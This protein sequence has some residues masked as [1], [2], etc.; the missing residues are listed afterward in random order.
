MGLKADTH[1]SL[2]TKIQSCP[3]ALL[4]LQFVQF[5]WYSFKYENC[6]GAVTEIPIEEPFIKILHSGITLWTYT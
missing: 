2:E 3:S 5:D 4:Q 1:D 6:P